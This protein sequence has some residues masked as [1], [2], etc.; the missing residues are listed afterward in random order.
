MKIALLAIVQGPQISGGDAL[1]NEPATF[2]PNAVAVQTEDGEELARFKDT[3][4]GRKL[5][6]DFA[7]A[8]MKEN[9]PPAL[10]LPDRALD[11][12]EAIR[13]DCTR[14][15][16]DEDNDTDPITYLL[17]FREAIRQIIGHGPHI[18]ELIE[19]DAKIRD[20]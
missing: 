5:A 11:T 4:S 16:D 18:D 20:L 17:S 19:E 3:P 7:V 14:C 6:H 8:W 2:G 13:N 15:L 1:R 9:A 10:T 12:L